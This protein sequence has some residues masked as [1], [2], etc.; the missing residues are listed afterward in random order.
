MRGPDSDIDFE[1]DEDPFYKRCP[2]CQSQQLIQ[3]VHGMPAFR[4]EFNESTYAARD[5]QGVW[6]YRTPEEYEAER[7]AARES[8]VDSANPRLNYTH[9]YGRADG[10]FYE[11]AGCV[12]EFGDPSVYLN[13]TCRACGLIF[14][15]GDDERNDELLE[16]EEYDDEFFDDEEEED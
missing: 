6:H 4:E 15:Y 9:Y 1:I 13:N 12:M 10:A 8:G 7:R 3:V 11:L 2:R 14:G 16:G 5:S